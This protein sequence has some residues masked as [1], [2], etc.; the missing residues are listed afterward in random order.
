MASAPAERQRMPARFIRCGT[1]WLTALST[2]PLADRVTGGAEGSEIEVSRCDDWGPD[3]IRERGI[4][5]LEF[6][7]KRWDIR[8]ADDQAREELLFVG[9]VDGEEPDLS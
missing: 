9:T 6:M 3:E 2:A 8:F 5:L 4:R 7:E 1:T